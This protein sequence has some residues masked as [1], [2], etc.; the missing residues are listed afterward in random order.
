[1]FVV[2]VRTRTCARVSFN[3]D[4]DLYNMH[5]RTHSGDGRLSP[6]TECMYW[7]F[8]ICV[9]VTSCLLSTVLHATTY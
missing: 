1:M 6:G 5:A 4:V 2:R 3:V 7:R 9:A 8:H